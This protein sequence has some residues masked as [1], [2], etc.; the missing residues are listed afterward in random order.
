VHAAAGGQVLHDRDSGDLT[1]EQLRS[2]RLLA[3]NLLSLEAGWTPTLAS[4]EV[5]TPCLVA[6]DAKPASA[7]IVIYSTDMRN[8]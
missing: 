5:C 8:F 6:Y 1:E 3:L 4:W 7:A 2:R